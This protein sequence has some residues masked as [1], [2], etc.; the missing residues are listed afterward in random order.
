[1]TGRKAV[2]AGIGATEFSKNSG[3]SEQRLAAEA[4]LGACRD[5][6]VDPHEID[7]LVTFTM[8]NNRAPAVGRMLGLTSVRL[9]AETMGGGGGGCG[10]V[11]L[12]V[13]A[14]EAG[15]AEV[16]ICYRAMNERSQQRLGQARAAAWDPHGLATTADLEAGW[17]APHGLATPAAYMALNA[18]R[19]MH[20]CGATSED[21]GQVAVAS[22]AWGATN[23]AAWFYERPI[24]LEDHQNSRVVADPIRL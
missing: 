7:G 23:P 4:I 18:R 15:V 2:I 9:I 1:M 20:E 16:V 8:D 10:T 12:A 17:N 22:R 24:T 11:A 14:V 3:R 6:N 5:A 19:Y 13:S 21:F